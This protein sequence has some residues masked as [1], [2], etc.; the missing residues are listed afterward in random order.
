MNA[1]LTLDVHPLLAALG[2]F[3]SK[4]DFCVDFGDFETRTAQHAGEVEEILR[5]RHEI[6]FQEHGRANELAIDVDEF[7][8]LADHLIL[9]DKRTQ[10]IVGTYRMLCSSWTDA[11]YSETE[12]NLDRVKALPGIKLEL[13]R[14]CIHTDYR[15]SAAIQMLWKGLTSYFTACEARYMFGC[16]SVDVRAG[17]DYG[18]L[19]AWLSAHHMSPAESQV[20]PRYTALP[21][22]VQL[23]GSAAI[24]DPQW[25]RRAERLAPALLKA[26]LRA[27][28]KVGGMPAYDPEFGTLDYFTLFDLA[29]L[30]E[31]YGKKFGVATT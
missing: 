7:D 22:F 8:A 27:G 3:H 18:L 5:L 14:A 31:N 23:E 6:F 15:N 13:G 21:A 19:H 10:K 17:M 20:F 26:Y 2:G 28:A 16:S 4:I 11:F 9:L 1:P 29:N 25:E 30:S 12:F 24:Q